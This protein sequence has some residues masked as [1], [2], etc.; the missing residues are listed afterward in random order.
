MVVGRVADCATAVTD[1]IAKV[2]IFAET[3]V[4]VGL[5]SATVEGVGDGIDI[6]DTFID[7][8]WVASDL[9]GG[10][11]DESRKGNV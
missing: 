9:G 8:C 11:S 5:T 10:S 7:T 1:G 2:G 6:G 4:V 3:D